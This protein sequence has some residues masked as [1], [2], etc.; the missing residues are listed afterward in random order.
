MPKTITDEL[1]RNGVGGVD[2][3][4][5]PVVSKVAPSRA[6]STPSKRRSLNRYPDVCFKEWCVGGGGMCAKTHHIEEIMDEPA[7]GG[8]DVT[9][10]LCV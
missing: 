9:L 8:V 4:V 7:V 5:A 3:G 2:A 10:N 1:S 6:L